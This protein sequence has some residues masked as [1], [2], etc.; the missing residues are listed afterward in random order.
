M[1]LADAQRATATDWLDVYT[2]HQL[3][4]ETTPTD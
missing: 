3:K 2:G 4:P 1:Q